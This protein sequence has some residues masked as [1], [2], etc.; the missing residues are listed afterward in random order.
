MNTSSMILFFTFRHLVSMCS[1]DIKSE[2]KIVDAAISGS[3]IF[4]SWQVLRFADYLNSL[5][6]LAQFKR[7]RYTES[8]T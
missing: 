6:T 2:R 5:G 3:D 4:F 8:D 7:H 1:A